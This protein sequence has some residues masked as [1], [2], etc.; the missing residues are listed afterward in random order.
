MARKVIP[1]YQR[2]EGDE[3]NSQEGLNLAIVN[4]FTD[5]RTE[6]KIDGRD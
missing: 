2:D 5:G 4:A 1:M 6:G 3:N